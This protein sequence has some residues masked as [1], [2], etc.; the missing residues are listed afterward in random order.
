MSLHLSPPTC[1]CP[2]CSPNPEFRHPIPRH[3]LESGTPLR[4][5]L[6]RVVVICWRVC[7]PHIAELLKGRTEGLVH[8]VPRGPSTGGVSCELLCAD[9]KGEDLPG[10]LT[11]P[12]RIEACRRSPRVGTESPWGEG[13]HSGL[14][15]DCSGP[16]GCST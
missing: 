1:L 15:V 8:V 6:A 12:G 7:L 3:R 5:C 10:E 2:G 14:E 11:S 13:L 4:A 16:G 9:D